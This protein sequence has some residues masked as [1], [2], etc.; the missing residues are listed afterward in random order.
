MLVDEVLILVLVTVRL[1]VAIISRPESVVGPKTVIEREISGI[2][3]VIDNRCLL[4]VLHTPGEYHGYHFNAALGIESYLAL[5][6]RPDADRDF[7]THLL[8]TS[9]Y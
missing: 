5:V 9:A 6:E 7:N 8:K 1:A 3:S 4:P 2:A